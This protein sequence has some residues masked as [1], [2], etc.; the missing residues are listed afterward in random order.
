MILPLGL[1]STLPL[2]YSA[3]PAHSSLLVG[4]I[5]ILPPS[6]WSEFDRY[7]VLWVP[8]V[9]TDNRTFC[10]ET[11][12][13][14]PCSTKVNVIISLGQ[15]NPGCPESILTFSQVAVPITWQPPSL[16]VSSGGEKSMTS[17]HSPG[18][19]FPVGT[20]LVS[21]AEMFEPQQTDESRIKCSFN[22]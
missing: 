16:S 14:G 15:F 19:L 5:I 6:I 21:Y 13:S 10:L 2:T 9:V 17:V 7:D 3:L 8:I 4:N 1:L 20:T 11:N 22:V 18:D 12:T